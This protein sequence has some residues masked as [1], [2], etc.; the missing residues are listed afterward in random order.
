MKKLLYMKKLFAF[1]LALCLIFGS[2]NAVL[3]EDTKNPEDMTDEELD[4]FY[5]IDDE[6]D[7]NDDDGIIDKADEADEQAREEEEKPFEKEEV[8]EALLTDEEAVTK[9]ASKLSL[10][11]IKCVS[12]NLNFVKEGENGTKVLWKSSHPD[13][14]SNEGKFTPPKK[15]TDVTITA[16]VSKGKYKKEKT[17][18]ATANNRSMYDLIV[19]FIDTMCEYGRDTRF[20][21][22]EVYRNNGDHRHGETIDMIGMNTFGK[23]TG[24]FLGMLNRDTMMYSTYYVAEWPRVTYNSD[25]R[26]SGCEVSPEIWLYEI[27]YDLTAM[28]GEKKY[29]KI[30]D[31]ILSFM[32]EHL[33]HPETGVLVW[34]RHMVYD[35]VTGSFNVPNQY[36]TNE[37]ETATW[38]AVNEP[39]WGDRYAMRSPFFIH[40]MF[41]LNYNSTHQ[42]MI[43]WLSACLQNAKDF[44]FSRHTYLDG[45]GGA[46]GNYMS[47][48]NPILYAF[49]WG[50]HYTGDPQFVEGLDYLMD[51]VERLCGYNENYVFTQE[52]YYGGN[53]PRV[54]WMSNQ[55]AGAVY[56]TEVLPIVPPDIRERMERFIERT[57]EYFYAE[58]ERGKSS[59]TS[60]SYLRTGQ[61]ASWGTPLSVTEFYQRW[62]QLPEGEFRDKMSDWILTWAD[63]YGFDSL[64][65]R[66][67]SSE[68]IPW[69][70]ARE[71][72]FF[73]V[74][75]EQTGDEKYLDR[76]LEMADFA[77]YD[78]WEMESL[79][80]AMTHAQKKWYESGWGS[81]EVAG[82]IWKAYFYGVER[83]T[84]VHPVNEAWEKNGYMTKNMWDYTTDESLYEKTKY[85]YTI[86]GEQSEK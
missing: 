42:H 27:M 47:M 35:P 2:F 68:I 39:D 38:D 43:S 55:L 20:F 32:L 44:T 25:E 19:D 46:S 51:F 85:V 22:K 7:A 9:D 73:R 40:K 28:T 10:G 65:S 1:L 62:C 82:E 23:K 26:S 83:D 45:S 14:I 24:L 3:A 49:A 41:E 63:K 59:F 54:A 81:C 30:A 58:P 86:G 50:Y 12:R 17:F 13:I 61:V 84:G 36:A 11:F 75:Y 18:I 53:R 67:K 37:Q 29:E 70:Y 72:G 71:M 33:I 4:E 8:Q 5:G 16:T 66:L 34:G 31:S 69:D 52:I 60:L 76:A 48:F 21:D 74:L 78:F 57:D 77:I 56:M 80:P 79:L 6:A 15:I 64:D